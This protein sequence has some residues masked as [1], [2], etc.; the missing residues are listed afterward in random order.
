MTYAEKTST[1]VSTSRAEIESLLMRHGAKGFGIIYDE[2]SHSALLGFKINNSAGRMMQ[3]RITISLPDVNDPRFGR[4][5]GGR[6]RYNQVERRREWEQACRAKWRALLLIV[7]AKLEAV[8]QGISTV[9]REFLADV[10]TIN[11]QTVQQLYGGDVLRLA[12]AE[13]AKP[14]LLAAKEA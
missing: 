5:P 12:E 4:S 6:K 14:L 9:E 13:G 8:A 3:V 1:S 10:V 7:K 2:E 11:G